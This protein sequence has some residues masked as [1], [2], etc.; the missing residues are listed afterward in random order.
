MF[1]D[2]GDILLQMS[3]NSNTSN[4]NLPEKLAKLEARMAGI[5]PPSVSDI[6]G[7]TGGIGATQ[8]L[9]HRQSTSPG[10]RE[11]IVAGGDLYSDSDDDA[12][13]EF[14]IMPNPRKR[15]VFSIEGE[16][17]LRNL[18]PQ[19]SIENASGDSREQQQQQQQ[20]Q[21]G[22]GKSGG[23]NSG[24][25]GRG[26]GGKASKG[27]TSGRVTRASKA[28]ELQANSA[29]SPLRG[30]PQAGP[31]GQATSDGPLVDAPPLEF[32]DYKAEES[33]GPSSG[34]VAGCQ[35]RSS[36]S[37]VRCKNKVCSPSLLPPPP[38]DSHL[39]ACP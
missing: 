9:K 24:R 7:A 4:P 18:K 17:E 23:T 11:V 33:N 25:Q 20:Q 38:F 6:R 12:G 36:L 29:S 13:G 22:Q 35:C 5:S 15:K 3:T 39:S 31:P 32:D 37:D 34:V 30:S 28:R 16:D 19:L 2:G 1:E 27:A 8:N 21:G 26:G 14:S 10:A